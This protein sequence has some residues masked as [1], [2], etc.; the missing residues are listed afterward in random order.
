MQSRSFSDSMIGMIGQV[1]TMIC[2]AHSRGSESL[3]LSTCPML[4]SFSH[5]YHKMRDWGQPDLSSSR[6]QLLQTVNKEATRTTSSSLPLPRLEARSPPLPTVPADPG[7]SHTRQS[8]HCKVPGNVVFS[9]LSTT[10][11]LGVSDN[12]CPLSC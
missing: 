5:L 4:G 10:Q 6:I 2:L 11:D 9:Q 1:A 12:L 8:S 3:T 7:L